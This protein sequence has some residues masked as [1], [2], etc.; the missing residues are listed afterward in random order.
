MPGCL[1]SLLLKRMEDVY[2]LNELGY[3]DHP[4]CFAIIANSDLVNAGADT[5]IGFQLDGSR[6]S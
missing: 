1:L 6:P 2:R 5:G 3:V 4:V